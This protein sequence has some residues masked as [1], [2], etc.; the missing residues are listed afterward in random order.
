MKFE[1]CMLCDGFYLFS[2]WRRFG[3]WKTVA[4][5]KQPAD[6]GENRNSLKIPVGSFISATSCR[7]GLEKEARQW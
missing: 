7:Q 3:F 2:K 6:L 5:G 1:L 4:G